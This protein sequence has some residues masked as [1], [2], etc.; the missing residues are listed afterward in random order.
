MDYLMYL[1]MT[2]LCIFIVCSLCVIHYV[3]KFSETQEKIFYIIE[4]YEHQMAVMNQHLNNMES[5]TYIVAQKS[6][7]TGG[8]N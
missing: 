5:D 3:K 7:R 6:L 8:N 1:E 2:V 4:G